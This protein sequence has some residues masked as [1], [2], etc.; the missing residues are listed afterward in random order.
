MDNED[1]ADCL[2]VIGTLIVAVGVVV[3]TYFIWGQL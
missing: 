1:W 2:F 3:I